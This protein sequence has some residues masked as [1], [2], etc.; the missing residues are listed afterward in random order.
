MDVR[1]GSFR[2]ALDAQ[3]V[4][5]FQIKLVFVGLMLLVMDGYDVQAIGYVAP[6]LSNLWKVDRSA[7]ASIFSAG[8]IGLTVGTLIFSPLSDR[9]GCRRVLIICTAMFGMLTLATTLVNSF[10]M[11]IALRFLTGLGLGGAMPSVIALVSDYA[12]TR[13]RNLMVMIA[14]VGFAIGG[15]SGGFVAAFAIQSFGWQSVFVIGGIVPLV[16]L[17]LI[18]AWLPES[19]PRLLADP[20]PRDRLSKVVAQVAPGWTA[21]EA[22]SIDIV[23]EKRFPV[24]ALFEKGYAIP[25]LLMWCIFVCNLL[26]V[27][28]FVNWTPSLVTKVGQSL[29]TAN[30]ATGM[31]QLGGI[32]G[33]LLLSLL[34]DRTGRTPIIMACGYFGAALCCC[35]FGT[36]A[37]STP[38]V[39]IGTAAAAGFCIVG[40]NGVANAFAG[41]YYPAAIRA[42]G[43]GWGLGMGRFGSIM[44]SLAGGILLSLDV[45]MPTLFACFAVPALI[46]ALCILLVRRSPDLAPSARLIA[47]QADAQVSSVV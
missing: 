47:P 29:Q 4:S 26:L 3:P 19:L 22:R 35:L 32:A 18:L 23:E 8:L 43:V 15:A 9:I 12:P 34:A 37:H 24:A 46:A 45:S 21:P 36:A 13:H 40:S 33:G 17:P 6:V 16:I 14:L 10:G 27:Y 28:F 25:T 30:I 39:L 2:N 44:G 38:A 41:S 42:T 5:S 1:I 31:F 11:L 7:F 20:A